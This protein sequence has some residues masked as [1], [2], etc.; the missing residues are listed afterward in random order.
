MERPRQL[1][2]VRHA[3]SARNEIKAGSTYF[4]DAEQRE[5]IKGVP[6]HDIPLTSRGIDQAKQTGIEIRNRF[7]IFDYIYHSG[8]KR[9]EDAARYILEAYSPDEREIIKVRHNPFIREIYS[10]YAYDMTT[11]E[12][13][14]AFPWLREYWDTFGGFMARPPGG[15]SLADVT[16]RVYTFLG[17]LFRDRVNQNVLVV[18]HGGTLSASGFCWKDGIT[19]SN[20][21]E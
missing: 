19:A 21:L 13:E 10:G 12:A 18:T 3:Q 16:N 5:P 15:E 4:V 7:G 9:T 2:L 20:N 1:V 11:V 8:Y 6:D 17:T 14:S